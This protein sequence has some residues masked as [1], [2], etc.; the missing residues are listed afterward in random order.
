MVSG[1]LSTITDI[2]FFLWNRHGHRLLMFFFTQRPFL[3]S[4]VVLTLHDTL[5]TTRGRRGFIVL[6]LI[7][8][9]DVFDS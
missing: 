3:T 4:V 1:N 9:G 5:L 6:F 8:F 7:F 2:V